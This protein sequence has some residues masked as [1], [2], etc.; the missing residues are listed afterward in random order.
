MG[1]PL[2]TQSTAASTG[3]L[4]S[5][6]AYRGFI[7]LVMASGGLAFPAVAK[8]FAGDPFWGFLAYQ[9]DHA[10]WAGCS[11]W[12][13]IQPSFMF[14]VGVAMPYSYASRRAK[15][16]APASIWGHTLL[17][18][19]VLIL[20]GIFLSSNWNKQTD[21]TFVNVLTQMGLGYSCVFLL[22]GRGRVVQFAAAIGILAGYWYLFYN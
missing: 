13:L 12:D 5:L 1:L 11:F 17:R 8:H 22:L 7:M 19:A 3:R 18:S 9:F 20:L 21:F 15:G 6:D 2:A 4:G 16:E 14:M 10:L